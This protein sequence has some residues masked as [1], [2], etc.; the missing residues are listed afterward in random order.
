MS[1]NGGLA[2][3]V[4]AQDA[5]YADVL[6]EL[7]RGR[8]ET[9]WMWFVFP[10]IAGLG[11]SQTARFY[12]IADLAEASAYLEHPVLGSRLIE[13]T[14]IVLAHKDKS[15]TQIF[16]HPDDIKFRSSI[17]LF[18]R[19]AEAP[20]IFDQALTQFS[21]GQPDPATLARLVG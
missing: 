3:F 1:E 12:A 2:R 8:K 13:C 15:L 14:Q 6:L 16:G 7:R 19:A 20:S 21:D 5:V 4:D 17:T 10:Q 11:S 18:A 9:H